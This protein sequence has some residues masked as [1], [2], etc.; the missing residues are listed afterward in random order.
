[1]SGSAEHA[2]PLDS[3]VDLAAHLVRIPSRAGI[4]PVEPIL[5]AAAAWLERR[6]LAPTR[7]RNAQDQDVALLLRLDGRAP[8][9]AILLNAC[10]DTAPFGDDA[11]WHASP[12]S[13][14]IADGRLWGRGA[15]DSKIGVAILAH[16]ARHLAAMPQ[17]PRGTV[18]VLFDA[19]EH[20]GAFG[21]VRAFVRQAAALPAGAVLGY[22]GDKGLTLGSRGFW[23]VKLHVAGR[24]A[25]SGATDDRGVNALSTAAALIAA[26]DAQ[27][28]PRG[29]EAPFDFGPCATVT[30]IAGGE[31]FSVVPDRAVCN[32]DIRLTPGFDRA[33]ARS[34]LERIVGAVD[35]RVAAPAATRIEAVDHWPPYAV[36]PD[37]KLVTSFRRASRQAFGRDLPAFVCGPSNIGNLLAA[38][39]VP[40]ICAPGVACGNVHGTDEYAELASVSR[41]YRMSCAAVVA[42]LDGA[43]GD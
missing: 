37:H 34:W 14:H 21:G 32:L 35:R 13:G 22:P 5:D 1:M 15:A 26:I 24:A 28:P 7:L 11:R 36:A 16:V 29:S 3:I 18:Y 39:G 4:D 40:T 2:V 42:F 19:D 10:L 33:A 30:R 8:G 17:R 20:T 9:P 25:H 27:P 12:T 43:D 41:V 31:G 38:H 6:G 23:R